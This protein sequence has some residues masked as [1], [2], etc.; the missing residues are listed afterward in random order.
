MEVIDKN[1]TF[2]V[3]IFESVDNNSDIEPKYTLTELS[4]FN[5]DIPFDFKRDDFDSIY[6]ELEKDFNW[7]KDFY[8]KV[9]QGLEVSLKDNEKEELKRLCRWIFNKLNHWKQNADPKFKIVSLC[10]IILN[11]FNIN[12][13]DYTKNRISNL[14]LENALSVRVKKFKV[15]SK[16]HDNTPIWE[17]E[18]IQRIGVSIENRDWLEIANNWSAFRSSRMFSFP[19]I[20]QKQTL[21][22][23]LEFCMENILQSLESYEDFFSMMSLSNNEFFTFNYRFLLASKTN[24][25]LLRFALLF[26]LELKNNINLSNDQEI[27]LAEIFADICKDKELA[28]TWFKIFN[29]YLVRFSF[30]SGA[31]GVF[32]AEH[33]SKEDIYIYLNS[34]G[35]SGFSKNI[36]DYH[37][38][39]R[40]ILTEV[41]ERFNSLAGLEKRTTLW[42][43]IYTKYTEHGLLSS[44]GTDYMN[45]ISYS[46]FD[47]AV[48]NYFIDCVH[49]KELESKCTKLNQELV[50][51]NSNWSNSKI[52]M[53]SKFYK[54]IA[55]LQPIYRASFVLDGEPHR[56]QKIGFYYVPPHLINDKKTCLMFDLVLD[57]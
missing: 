38:E 39:D 24:N 28:K 36:N 34:L 26:D 9:E 29:R 33:A 43:K 1:H 25:N 20:F 22:F 3:E 10:F 23:L 2:W 8:N 53:R 35:D 4:S 21:L 42:S 13:W 30:F 27:I 18:A 54:L 6:S 32:L 17:K 46:V 15:S 44:D 45:G 52:V 19:N 16:Y 49:I 48:V 12:V 37:N 5:I 57:S 50:N 7:L 55:L 31:F 40:K 47:Y 56:L 41:F 14:E 51:I 11:L